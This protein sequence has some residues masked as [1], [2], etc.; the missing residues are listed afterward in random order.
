MSR[1]SDAACPAHM[2][3]KSPEP[4]ASA[5]ARSGASAPAASGNSGATSDIGPTSRIRRL[6]MPRA[7]RPVMR[8]VNA[9]PSS[10]ADLSAARCGAE[11]FDSGHHRYFEPLPEPRLRQPEME[12][13]D[14]GLRLLDHIAHDG[15]ERGAVARGDRRGGIDRELAVI[16]RQAFPPARLAGVVEHRRRMAEEIEIYG[17]L[18]AGADLRHL[19]AD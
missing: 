4:C 8:L 17:F 6:I 7:G 19:L 15:I 16:R 1:P 2:G 3:E 10:R 13:H 12:A 18:R 5:L 14:L 9:V 11:I